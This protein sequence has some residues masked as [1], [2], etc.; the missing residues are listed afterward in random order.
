[1]KSVLD[2]VSGNFCRIAQPE[3]FQ[4]GLAMRAHRKVAN[5]QGRSDIVVT[6]AERNHAHDFLLSRR[7]H[8]DR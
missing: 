6:R 4:Q 7:R 1:M 5:L 8:N 2:G 3:F